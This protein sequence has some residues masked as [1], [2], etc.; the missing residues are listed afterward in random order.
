MHIEIILYISGTLLSLTDHGIKQAKSIQGEEKEITFKIVKKKI[1]KKD[2][3]AIMGFTILP[4]FSTQF[5]PA[6]PLS[7]FNKRLP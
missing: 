4:H 6:F 1:Q 5:L 2:N 3:A 7:T